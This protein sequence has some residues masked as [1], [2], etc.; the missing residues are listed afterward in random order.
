MVLVIQRKFHFLKKSNVYQPFHDVKPLLFVN[1]FREECS[2]KGG[3]N[4]GSCASGFGVC[5]TCKLMNNAVITQSFCKQF[6]VLVYIPNEFLSVSSYSWM[7]RFKFRKLH[8]FWGTI[9]INVF[10]KIL[11]TQ[12]YHFCLFLLIAEY[13]SSFW[14]MYRWYIQL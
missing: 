10:P 6:T 5:C 3:L 8:I 4:A 7:W 2:N 12:S 14:G 11:T 9:L 1:D 13:F